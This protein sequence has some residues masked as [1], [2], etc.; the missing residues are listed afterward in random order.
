VPLSQ[1]S[2]T[3]DTPTKLNVRFTAAA[4]GGKPLATLHCDKPFE[5]TVAAPVV[6]T[7]AMTCVHVPE[8]NTDGSMDAVGEFPTD[9]ENVLVPE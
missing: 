3:L 2:E 1:L 7:V 9:T 4:G 5:Y 6:D 8:T